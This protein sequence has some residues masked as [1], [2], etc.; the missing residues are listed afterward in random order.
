MTST[1][2][3]LNHQDYSREIELLGSK[4]LGQGGD[5]TLQMYDLSRD[6]RSCWKDNRLSTLGV[7]QTAFK[8]LFGH[9]H[10]S[11]TWVTPPL[12]W[13]MVEAVSCCGGAFRH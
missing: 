9:Y 11:A 10:V 1:I 7:C 12:Q 4:G 5:D 3:K 13:S 8:G 2:V 6:E